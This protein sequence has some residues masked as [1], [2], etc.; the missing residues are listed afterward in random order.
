ML[1]EPV[2]VRSAGPCRWSGGIP[3]RDE[4]TDDVRGM[5]SKAESKLRIDEV[6]VGGGGLAGGSGRG[7][8]VSLKKKCPFDF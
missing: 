7:G 8:G 6:W 5:D 1:R 2:R 3:T 4:S